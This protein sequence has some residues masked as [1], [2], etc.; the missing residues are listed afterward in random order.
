MLSGARGATRRAY[1]VIVVGAG[2]AGCEAASVCADA[3]RHVLLVTTSLDTVYNTLGDEVSLEPP[4]HTLMAQLHAELKDPDGA[5]GN[6]ALHR[7]AKYRL[8]ARA[9]LHLLQSSVSALRVSSYPRMLGVETW[10]G[11]EREAGVVALCVGSFLQARLHVGALVETAG[12]LSEMA[13]DDLYEDLR[14]RGLAF[15]NVT[16]QAPAVAGSLPYEVRCQVLA[17]GQVDAE[18]GAVLALPGLYAAGVCAR[19]YLPFEAA[20]SEGQRLGAALVEATGPS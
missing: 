18:T 2:I 1:D 6:W 19:G 17:D 7:A 20:A 15:R 4:A 5:V 13:Y 3:G 12:R 14:R 11:V 10:E 9:G 8:E 16:L